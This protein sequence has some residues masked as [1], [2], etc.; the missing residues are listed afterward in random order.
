MNPK[1]SLSV[2]RLRHGT[3]CTLFMLNLGVGVVHAD[4]ISQ[5]DV[6]PDPSAGTVTNLFVGGS[7]TTVGAGSVAVDSNGAITSF[8][9]Q[10]TFFGYSL[11]SSGIGTV[12]A[13]ATWTDSSFFTIARVFGSNG[14][15]QVAG[16]NAFAGGAGNVTNVG[17]GGTGSL[18]V[19]NGGTFE[20][21]FIN[22]GRT[23]G[24]VGT[25]NVDGAASSVLLSGSD[26]SSGAF[27]TVGRET[28]SQG[29]AHFT[30]GAQINIQNFSDTN[31]AGSNVA[32]NTGSNGILNVSG[33]PRWPPEFPPPVA[34]P[35]SPRVTTGR[36]G[37]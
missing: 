15:L 16:T 28:G 3:L 21:L 20:G 36:V 24:A 9:S 29:T 13:G 22:V 5:G 23:N 27:L 1:P 18:S 12:S 8:T 7:T 17:F 37:L 34:T 35:N 19:I 14:G 4:I 31:A 30:N 32:R 6:T 26:G 11:G 33:G 25:M 10:G 2:T